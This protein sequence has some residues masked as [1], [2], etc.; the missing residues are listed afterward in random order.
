MIAYVSLALVSMPESSFQANSSSVVLQ[1][2][3]K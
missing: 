3:A 1:H 2:I